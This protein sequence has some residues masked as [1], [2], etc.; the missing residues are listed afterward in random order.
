MIFLFAEDSRHY[1][2]GLR[3]LFH[4]LEHRV[5]AHILICFIALV[6]WRSLE[7]WLQADGLGSCARQ[8]LHELDNLR[9]MD[10]IAPL[11]RGREARLRVVGKP[12]RLFLASN[13]HEHYTHAAELSNLG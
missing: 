11:H 12:E 10:V 7:Q 8:V 6:M 13:P 3:P 2:L 4:C 5:Q 9:S 1:H